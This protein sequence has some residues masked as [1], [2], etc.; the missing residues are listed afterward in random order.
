[1]VRVLEFVCAFG[2]FPEEEIDETLLDIKTA[3]KEIWEI[4]S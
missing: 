4:G 1:V 3:K 2:I